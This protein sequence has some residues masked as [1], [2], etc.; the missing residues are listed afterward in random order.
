MPTGYTADVAEGKVTE[1][2]DFAFQCA[3]AFGALIDMRDDP[4]D[5]PIP[6]KVE[7]HSSYHETQIAKAKARLDVLRA[8]SPKQVALA[9]AAA[10]AD[11]RAYHEK[12]AAQS[13]VTR[14]RYNAMLT[15][16]EAWE[17][18]SPDHVEMKNFM[19]QQLRESI[20]FDTRYTAPPRSESYDPKRWLT[21]E[22]ER[23]ERSIA[24]HHKALGEELERTAN[25][26]A[27]LKALRES[28]VEPP[29]MPNH[30]TLGQT[31]DFPTDDGDEAPLFV[32]YG[33]D[34]ADLKALWDTELAILSGL[35]REKVV[36]EAKNLTRAM[37]AAR[38]SASGWCGDMDEET[39]A[40]LWPLV[41]LG[42]VYRMR[43]T[44]PEMEAR[45][46]KALEMLEGVR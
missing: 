30:P 36:F 35:E 29:R 8:M 7:A 20:D 11:A 25:R 18:P 37:F 17:P 16:V 24:Y 12:E 32:L 2:R 45:Y 14:E 13:A 41:A 15:K 38:H 4:K 27:W 33:D 21:T 5:A 28:L 44:S 39:Y 10:W 43:E 1:F 19:R 40:A 9:A 31:L 46:R 3:R 34:V 42:I 26:N 22:V 6:E 23:Q